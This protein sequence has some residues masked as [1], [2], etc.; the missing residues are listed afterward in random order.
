M[1]HLD[2]I[3]SSELE[4]KFQA[5]NTAFLAL[6]ERFQP[7]EHDYRSYKLFVHEADSSSLRVLDRDVRTAVEHT[8]QTLPTPYALAEAL[9]GL[10]ERMEN[11]RE[12]WQRWQVLISMLQELAVSYCGLQNLCCGI[13]MG[14]LR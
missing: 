14:F 4:A 3:S 1:V 7:L 8:Q 12:T 13:L 10:H 9:D 2:E 6:V 11:G 5:T